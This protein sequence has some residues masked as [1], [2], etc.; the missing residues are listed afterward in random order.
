MR[1]YSG[2]AL[3]GW[4]TETGCDI[5]RTVADRDRTQSQS[6]STIPTEAS[7]TEGSVTEQLW[8]GSDE[9]I[10]WNGQREDDGNNSDDRFCRPTEILGGCLEER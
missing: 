7:D 8:P 1:E 10:Q 2:C 4:D 6:S 3:T 5:H 9:R